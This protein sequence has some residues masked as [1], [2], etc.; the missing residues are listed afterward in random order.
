MRWNVKSR[1]TAVRSI[2]YRCGS[3]A[4]LT[5]EAPKS[6]SWTQLCAWGQAPFSLQESPCHP[7]PSPDTK[8]Q[9]QTP[10]GRIYTL[11][12]KRKRYTSVV[13]LGAV[14]KLQPLCWILLTPLFTSVTSCLLC[15]S[16]LTWYP[17]RKFIPPKPLFSFQFPS[18]ATSFELLPFSL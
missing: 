2:Q 13:A 4:H 5:A 1:P 11:Q 18:C 7:L 10:S 8:Q 16:Q 14:E 12:G 17:A 3:L 9:P 15:C 6:P